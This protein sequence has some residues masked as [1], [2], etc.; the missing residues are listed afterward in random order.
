MTN[1]DQRG[2]FV[3]GE[4]GNPGGRPPKEFSPSAYLRSKLEEKPAILDRWIAVCEKGEDE[5]ALRG[6]IALVNRVEG[7]PKQATE[8]TGKDGGVM[9]VRY[10]EGPE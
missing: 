6:L 7:M 8:V 10:V 5:T 2:R 1:R 9:L 3:A 4:S